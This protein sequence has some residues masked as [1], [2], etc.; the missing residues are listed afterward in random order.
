MN[1]IRIAAFLWGAPSLLF[2]LLYIASKYNKNILPDF[3][4][5][6]VYGTVLTIIALVVSYYLRFINPMLLVVGNFL[7]FAV[8]FYI[9]LHYKLYAI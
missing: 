9:Y 3:I 6:A 2:Y 1:Y 7:F 8:C 4:S 5:H